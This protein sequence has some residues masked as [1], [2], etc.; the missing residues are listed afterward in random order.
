MAIT[1]SSRQLA[2]VFEMVMSACVGAGS[3]PPRDLNRFLKTG[4]M[5]SIMASTMIPM[6]DTTMIG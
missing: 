5:S 4:T 6:T 2:S 3:L 1:S